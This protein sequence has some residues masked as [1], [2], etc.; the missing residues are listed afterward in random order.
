MTFDDDEPPG[1]ARA[2][3][4]VSRLPLALVIGLGAAAVI[5]A[6]LG[7][8]GVSVAAYAA[9]LLGG[10]ILLILYRTQLVQT[11]M[12]IDGAAVSV[13]G[14][15]RLAVLA[16]VAGCLANGIVIGLWIAGLELWF[17]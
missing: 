2:A 4:H 16:I 15:E 3:Q 11:S 13:V 14:I 7:M 6:F 1:V 9:L 12:S 8:L 17:Q 10:M 5:V